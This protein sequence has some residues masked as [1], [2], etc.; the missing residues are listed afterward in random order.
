MG[1]GARGIGSRLVI[2]SE[3]ELVDGGADRRLL[4]H[5]AAADLAAYPAGPELPRLILIDHEL[6][7]RPGSAD[8]N[9]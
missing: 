7:L 2:V 4:D 3:K 5:L 1:G 9:T 6:N 8:R